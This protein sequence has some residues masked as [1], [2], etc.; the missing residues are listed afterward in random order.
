MQDLANSTEGGVSVEEAT[1][2]SDSTAT[3]REWRVVRLPAHL[4]DYVDVAL[5]ARDGE[6][7]S[8]MEAMSCPKKEKWLQAMSEECTSLDKNK[9][10]DLVELPHGKRAIGCKWVFK[11]KAPLSEVEQP[12]SKARLVAKGF[13]QK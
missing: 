3:R 10:W 1:K 2:N 4:D 6:L 11:K 5:F 8:F 9:T 13:V 12:A 7:T